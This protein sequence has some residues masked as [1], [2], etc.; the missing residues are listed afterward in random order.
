MPVPVVCAPEERS[1]PEGHVYALLVVLEALACALPVI[2][3]QYNGA[4]ELLTPPHDG[5]VTEDPHNHEHLAWCM[6]QL[7]DP[8]RRASCAQAARR[9]AS[10]WTFEMH[11]R[12]L[13]QVFVEAA[14]RKR[15]A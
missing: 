2:T 4:S 9:T 1:R 12:Q 15:A 11:Y 3:S 14:A 13:S 5:F 7:L 8:G 6:S 10:Q